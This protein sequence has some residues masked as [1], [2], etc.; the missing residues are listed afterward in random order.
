MMP[1]ELLGPHAGFILACYGITVGVVAALFVWLF[2]ARARITREIAA[3]EAEGVN[4]RSRPAS[5]ETG[6]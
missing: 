5:A 4:R 3:L 2:A 1:V 6:S